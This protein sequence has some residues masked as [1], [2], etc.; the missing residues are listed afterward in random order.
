MNKKALGTL[1]ASSTLLSGISTY[2]DNLQQ[3]KVTI[4]NVNG[5]AEIVD[6]SKGVLSP[7]YAQKISG[8]KLLSYKLKLNENT[9]KLDIVNQNPVVNNLTPEVQQKLTSTVEK[10][11]EAKPKKNKHKKPNKNKHHNKNKHPQKKP[12]PNTQPPAGDPVNN[13]LLAWQ[14]YKNVAGRTPEPL[15]NVAQFAG[16]LSGSLAGLSLGI[17]AA[18][19]VGTITSPLPVIGSFSP[20]FA[21]GSGFA[22]SSIANNLTDFTV[23]E[24]VSFIVALNSGSPALRTAAQ[25]VVNAAGF[26]MGSQAIFP[27]ANTGY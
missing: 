1:L 19:I 6:Y 15:M 3:Q 18:T 7:L 4:K 10:I 27:D 14:N 12:V 13:L 17:P 9:G 21:V 8:N 20:S 24:I 26:T 11:K 23:N 25:R 22:V 2:A 16:S 5:Q